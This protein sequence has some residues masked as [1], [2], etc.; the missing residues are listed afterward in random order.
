MFHSEVFLQYCDLKHYVDHVAR[1]YG[2]DDTHVAECITVSTIVWYMIHMIE[3]D[4]VVLL[5][6]KPTSFSLCL[7]LTSLSM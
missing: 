4:L 2:I 3:V 7:L 5:Q 6:V 1:S